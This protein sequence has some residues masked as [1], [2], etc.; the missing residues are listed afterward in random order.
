MNALASAAD[1]SYRDPMPP[2]R[3][4]FGLRGRVPRKVFWI[5]GVV[6]PTLLVGYVHALLGIAGVRGQ[7]VEAMLNLVLLWL[8]LAVPAKRWHDLDHSG[9]WALLL[10]V[11][12]VGPLLLIAL[13]GFRRGTVGPNRFG[14]DLTADF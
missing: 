6:V 9:W 12:V 7:A 10:F 5:Y 2:S 11:P 14:P 1:T 3:I 13:L 4:F 8:A